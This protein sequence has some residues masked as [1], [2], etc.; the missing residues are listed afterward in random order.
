MTKTYTE[1]AIFA[2]ELHIKAAKSSNTNILN[3]EIVF[4][5]KGRFYSAGGG[6]IGYAAVVQFFAA[7]I[8]KEDASMTPAVVPAPA[9]KQPQRTNFEW[10]SLNQAT[11]DLFFNIC[12]Q[13]QTISRDHSM[14][15]PVLVKELQ[16]G[17]KHAPRLS[18]LKKAGL[19][20]GHIGLKKSHKMLRLTER[21]KAIWAAYVG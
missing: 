17:L 7:Q 10:D 13:M 5:P 21:G 18:N 6:R 9:L 15:V 16:I 4:T 19:F 20:V 14:V 12:E 2:V 11:K 8:E 3:R 1:Q